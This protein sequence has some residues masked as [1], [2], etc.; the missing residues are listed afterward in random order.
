MTAAL[1]VDLVAL[2]AAGHSGLSRYT[3]GLTRALDEVAGE[4]PALRLSVLTTRGGADALGLR[5]LPVRAIGPR[6]RHL[7]RGPLR[8]ALDQ[9]SAALSPGA[10]LHFFDLSGPALRPGRPFT[11]TIHDA[12]VTHGYHGGP[13]LAYKRLLCPWA[14]RTARAVVAVSRFAA[15]EAT[16]RFGAPAGRLHIIPS[17]PGLDRAPGPPERRFSDGRPFLLSVGTIGA[18]KN[19]PLVVAALEA[20]RLDLDLVIAGRPGSGLPELR[21]AVRASGVAGRVRVV[22]DAS[23]AEV[24]DLYRRAAALLLPSRYEGFAFTPLEAM[25]RGCPVL[26]SDI[27][28][29]REV[30]GE[31]AWLLP[32]DDVPA[33]GEALRRVVGDPAVRDDLVR[34]GAGLVGRYS[35]QVAARRLCG[36]LSEA[37]GAAR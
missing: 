17:G 37:G 1:R 32:V 22:T 16:R 35:W 24:D 8:V 11:T 5:R 3:V 19:L 20:S 6:S 2:I 15:D 26:V 10:L 9:V 27:P 34:R 25:A 36:V 23:D 29:V 21:E 18:N 4:F 14:A 13:V 33:W 30:S 31:G 12:S 28:A 7:D